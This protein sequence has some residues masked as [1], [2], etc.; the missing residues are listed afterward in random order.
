MVPHLAPNATA[1]RYVTCI[2]VY[3]NI[4][5]G[6]PLVSTAKTRAHT[7]DGGKNDVKTF[8]THKHYIRTSYT[9]TQT[10]ND[11]DYII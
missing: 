9:H 6:L 7:F 5:G 4:V 8:E 3:F 10:V 2:K 1:T 11:G